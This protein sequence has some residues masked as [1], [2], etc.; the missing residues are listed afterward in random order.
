MVDKGE[1]EGD[2]IEMVDWARPIAF[3]DSYQ[4]ITDST[5]TGGQFVRPADW[6]LVLLVRF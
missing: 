5:Q 3:Q 2:T 6:E 4:K 1:M